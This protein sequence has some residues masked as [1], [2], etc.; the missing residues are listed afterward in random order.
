V[1]G[2]EQD[3]EPVRSFDDDRREAS[4]ASRIAASRTASR[5][6]ALRAS[7]TA[8]PS[9]PVLGCASPATEL[10]ISA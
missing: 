9:V 10:S 2:L 1:I 5:R 8:W 4:P 3:E 6:R 7:L